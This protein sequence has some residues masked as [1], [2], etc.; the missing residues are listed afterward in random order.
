MR[1]YWSMSRYTIPVMVVSMKKRGPYTLSLLMAQNTF[2]FGLSQTCSREAR[3]WT[4]GDGGGTVKKESKK[5]VETVVNN[6]QR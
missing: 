4:W 3:G 1:N 2:T 6:Y 5:E